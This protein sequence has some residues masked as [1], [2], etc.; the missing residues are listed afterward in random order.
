M[1]EKSVPVSVIMTVRNEQDSL[2]HLLD[3][4]AEQ[5][6]QPGEVVVV[7]GGS[8][9]RTVEVARSY[10]GRLP[11]RVLVR[12]GANISEGRNA[13]IEVAQEL[14]GAAVI[15]R[16]RGSQRLSSGPIIH[17]AAAR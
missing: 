7:D 13:A 8:T 17:D 12:P 2:P 4:L 14:G 3:S 6:V 9:D 5:T 15:G 11:V 16:R 1:A 10:E